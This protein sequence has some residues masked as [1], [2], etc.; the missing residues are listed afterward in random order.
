M[1]HHLIDVTDVA[2]QYSIDKYLQ[3]VKRVVK[4]IHGRGHRVLVVGGSG[5]YLKAFFGPIVDDIE[6]TE[7]LRADIRGRFESQSLEESVEELR[8]MNPEGLGGL[9]VSNPRRVLNCLMRCRA[10]GLPIRELK[11]RFA[12]RPGLFDGFP[13]R[14]LILSRSREELERRFTQ[15]GG[16]DAEGWI[17]RGSEG[18]GERRDRAKSERGPVDRIPGDLG[19]FARGVRGRGTSPIDSAKH[20]T[21]HKKATDLVQKVSP[22]RSG[23]RSEQG[24]ATR[25]VDGGG[26][27]R[28]GAPMRN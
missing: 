9:D 4:E 24:P 18:F 20:A 19:F 12:R 14:L 27:R 22:G 2:H 16:S 21:T 25:E 23:I 7:E 8:R 17:G 1:P 11:R 15:T 28:L 26:K 5:F 13:R 10:S 3:E 6:I